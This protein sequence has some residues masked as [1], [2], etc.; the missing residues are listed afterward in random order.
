MTSPTRRDRSAFRLWGTYSLLIL[1]VSVL[2]LVADQGFKLWMLEG[3]DI[4][5]R[6]R[7]EVTPFL[8]LVMVWNYGISYG[9]FQQDGETGRWV[10]VAVTLVVTALFWLW[11]VHA[12]RRLAAWGFALVIAGALGNGI[13]RVVWGAVAD[14]FHFHAGDFSWYVFNLAD[15]W[16]VAG[17]AALMY[18]S[19]RGSPKDAAKG[20]SD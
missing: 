20:G 19:F 16:I 2:G 18:D 17:V 8:D 12:E 7:V 13:D 1:V 9:L 6:G 11:G 4:A 3:Y 15:V 14:F 5:S 10:L